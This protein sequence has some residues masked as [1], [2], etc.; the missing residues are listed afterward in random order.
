VVGAD[1]DV[2]NAIAAIR[3][4]QPV[5]LPTDTVYGLVTSASREEYAWRLYKLKGRDALQPTALLAASV[6]ALY[7]CVPELRA[8]AGVIIEELLPGPYT[9][10][11]PNPARRYPWLTGTRTDA[12]G[13]RV[14]EM[15]EAAARVVESVRCVTATSANEPG[16]P[17]PATLDQ[18]PTRI[19]EACAAEIDAGALGGTS[20]AVIDF[21]GKEP[22]VIREGIA[23]AADAI[24]RVRRA[25]A[26]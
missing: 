9:L 2:Q 10:V 5:L 8:L 25:L 26:A 15:P 13:V 17:S 22:Y 19:R 11:L 20:S 6:E 24:A 23:P 18:V 7:G 21:T 12:I 1:D 14:V 4:G 3:A 16:E